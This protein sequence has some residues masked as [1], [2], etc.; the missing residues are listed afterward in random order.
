MLKI[1]VSP[2]LCIVGGQK[3]WRFCIPAEKRKKKICNL[4]KCTKGAKIVPYLQN[5]ELGFFY[6]LITYP[7]SLVA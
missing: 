4:L 2:M 7:Q 6:K 5:L 3:V 1:V